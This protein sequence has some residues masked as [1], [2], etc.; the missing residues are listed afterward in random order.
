MMM[1]ATLAALLN[2]KESG[3]LCVGPADQVDRQFT[4]ATGRGFNPSLGLACSRGWQHSA[5]LHGHKRYLLRSL[6]RSTADPSR[7][8]QA[9]R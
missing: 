3:A 7:N 4:E 9:F 2:S 5:V 1:S 6:L 8:W